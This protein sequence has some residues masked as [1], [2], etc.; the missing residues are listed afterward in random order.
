MQNLH[1]AINILPDTHKSNIANRSSRKKG[2]DPILKSFDVAK[3]CVI[4]PFS[5][6]YVLLFK[7]GYGEIFLLF[8]AGRKVIKFGGELAVT[9]EEVLTALVD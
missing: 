1:C 4:A 7:E 5:I 2:I 3:R 8:D 9:D 6:F